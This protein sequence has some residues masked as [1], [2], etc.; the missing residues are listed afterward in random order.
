MQAYLFRMNNS[1]VPAWSE[2]FLKDILKYLILKD[3]LIS[4]RFTRSCKIVQRGLV[5]P[6]LVSPSGYFLH[7]QEIDIGTMYVYAILSHE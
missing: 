6:N 4:Y 7:N 2:S 1:N 3:I 5:Y